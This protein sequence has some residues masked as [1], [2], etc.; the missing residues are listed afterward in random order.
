MKNFTLST[1]LGIATIATGTMLAS[2]PAN[3]VLLAG[4]LANADAIAS[5][6]FTSNGTVTFKSTSYAAGGFSPVV[7]LFNA[8]GTYYTGSNEFTSAGDLNITTNLATGN[9][10]AVISAFNRYFE[11]SPPTKTN[12]SQGFDGTGTFFGRTSAYALD[13]TSPTA[14]AVPEPFTI[15]GTMIGAA[16]ALRM[17]KRLEA[18][19]KL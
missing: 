18:T 3:A 8:N 12:L 16:S 15:V 4:S 13:I 14:T 19:N 10:I 9:Y 17:R 7:T 5:T 1:I 2:T 11:Y 6:T